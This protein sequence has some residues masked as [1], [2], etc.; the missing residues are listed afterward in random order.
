MVCVRRAV[1]CRT[2]GGTM[3]ESP[4]RLD[5]VDDEGLHE[6]HVRPRRRFLPDPAPAGARVTRLQ[7]PTG[8]ITEASWTS[9]WG[10]ASPTPA[11]SPALTAIATPP[12]PIS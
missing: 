1:R 2:A 11:T 12:A 7:G 5:D 3:A 4:L 6:P 9:V 8:L 10:W